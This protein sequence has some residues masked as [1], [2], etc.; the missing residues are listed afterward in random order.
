V[1]APRNRG[2]AA[3]GVIV[4]VGLAGCGGGGSS[5]DDAAKVSDTVTRL[6][7]ALGRGDGAGVCSLATTAGQKTLA[8]ALPNSTCPKVVELVSR[9][10]SPSQKAGLETA[11]VGKVHINGSH[12]SV[13]NTSIT[14][15]KGSLKGFLQAGSAPTRLTKQSDGSWKI[16]G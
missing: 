16:S 6:L 10:L 4:A 15:P 7:H 3:L 8:R 11:K 13:P 12:A 9:H 2:L 14:S 5:S 1:A